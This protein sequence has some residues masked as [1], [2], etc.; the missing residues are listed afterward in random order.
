MKR[1]V[2]SFACDGCVRGAYRI[3]VNPSSGGFWLLGA[4]SATCSCPDL[5]WLCHHGGLASFSWHTEH[6]LLTGQWVRLRFLF[7]IFVESGAIASTWP[8]YMTIIEL[9][10]GVIAPPP[11]AYY[12][13]STCTLTLMVHLPLLIYTKSPYAYHVLKQANE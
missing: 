11:Q 7:I 12:I 6:V 1:H 5:P 8:M 10:E 9:S 4:I 2:P 13:S 3:L